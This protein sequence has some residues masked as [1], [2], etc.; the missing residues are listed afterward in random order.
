MKLF[1]NE[2]MKLSSLFT[3]F[4]DPDSQF[5]LK[6]SLGTNVVGLL[7]GWLAQNWYVL[8]GFVVASVVPVV[9]S[10]RK[11]TEELR[12]LRIMNQIEEAKAKK[13]LL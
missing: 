12:H 6:M 7:A 13:E 9:M 1:N 3:S 2:I 4:H 10:W 8:G 5:M 11:H